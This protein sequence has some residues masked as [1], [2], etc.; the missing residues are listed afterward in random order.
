MKKQDADK[1]FRRMQNRNV[2]HDIV[3]EAIKL[4]TKLTRD[5]GTDTQKK[6]ITKTDFP[7]S[8]GRMAIALITTS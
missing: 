5:T 2:H 8:A 3:Q 1:W 6:Y 4:A 7:A